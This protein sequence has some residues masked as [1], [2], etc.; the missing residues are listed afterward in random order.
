MAK[1]IKMTNRLTFPERYSSRMI[2][3]VMWM[4]C[5]YVVDLIEQE[6]F[7]P[8]P[9]ALQL[10]QEYIDEELWRETMVDDDSRY[11]HLNPSTLVI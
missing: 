2:K 3:E 5:R 9:K 6:I 1:Y 7:K 11:Q 10:L 8:S 4:D